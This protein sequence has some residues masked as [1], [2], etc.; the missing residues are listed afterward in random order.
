MK[1]AYGSSKGPE[2]IDICQFD[3]VEAQYNIYIYI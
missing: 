3:P 1:D 2:S